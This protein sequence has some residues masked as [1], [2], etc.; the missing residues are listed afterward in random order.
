MVH[1]LHFLQ[2]FSKWTLVSQLFHFLSFPFVPS[3]CILSDRPKLFVFSHQVLLW[4]PI[5]LI[6]WTLLVVQCTQCWIRYKIYQGVQII[7]KLNFSL[8][9]TALVDIV[10]FALYFTVVSVFSLVHILLLTF[11]IRALVVV[12]LIVSRS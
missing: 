7:M 2:P 11:V 4:H 5:C 12:V 6:P 1:Y 9:W 10:V 3:V 8:N